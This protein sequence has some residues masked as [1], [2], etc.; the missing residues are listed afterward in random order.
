MG[1]FNGL[2]NSFILKINHLLFVDNVIIFGSK[3]FAEW[4]IIKE[5]VDLF[6]LA[7]GMTFSITKSV[8]R[9]C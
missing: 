1:K 5:L 7:Y 2:K 3:S 4:N 9:H 6:C 8:F